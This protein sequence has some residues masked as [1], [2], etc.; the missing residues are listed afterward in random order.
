MSACARRESISGSDLQPFAIAEPSSQPPLRKDGL[1]EGAVT[2]KVADA[3][4]GFQPVP[5][6]LHSQTFGTCPPGSHMGTAV[7]SHLSSEKAGGEGDHSGMISGEGRPLSGTG[8]PLLRR[9]ESTSV[10]PGG[11]GGQREKPPGVGLWNSR[12]LE[13]RQSC[14]GQGEETQGCLCPGWNS[15]RQRALGLRTLKAKK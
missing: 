1:L 5:C 8:H 7:G 10:L 6:H 15:R 4:V 11:Q 12:N 9:V 13:R 14:Q 3:V 2:L